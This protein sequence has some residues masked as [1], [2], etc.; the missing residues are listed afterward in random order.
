[1]SNIL[2]SKI[3]LPISQSSYTKTSSYDSMLQSKSTSG[4]RPEGRSCWRSPAKNSTCDY[5]LKAWKEQNWW[6]TGKKVCPQPTAVL[7][8][9]CQILLELSEVKW[10]KV[11]YPF[12]N[13]Q[14][15][16]RPSKA[17]LSISPTKLPSSQKTSWW[18]SKWYI[19]FWN[20]SA[21]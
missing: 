14:K 15:T 7:T 21:N 1:M 6:N 4:L 16:Q 12:P 20:A 2:G 18:L 13:P 9:C 11:G 17:K 8:W 5:Q 3:M 10:E 19:G